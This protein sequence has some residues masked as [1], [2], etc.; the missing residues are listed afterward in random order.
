M[1]SSVVSVDYELQDAVVYGPIP[2]RRLGSSLGINPLPVSYKLCDF[3][4]VYCQYG[5]TPAKGTGE[6][7]KRAPELLAEIE[8]GL[9]HHQREGAPVDCITI[10]GNGEPTLHPDFPKLVEGLLK[11]RDRFFPSARVGVLSDSSQAYRSE[12]RGALEMLDDRYMKLDAGHAELHEKI[13]KPRGGFDFNRVIESLRGLRDIVSQSLF[14]QGSYDNTQTEALDK[15]I[16]TIGFIQPREVQVYSLDRKPADIGLLKVSP[17]RLK[18][19]A[20]VCQ[21]MTGIPT[22]V[23]D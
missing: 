19:I 11:L 5:W 23:Y 3:D 7:L 18:E 17:A 1:K 12:I 6:R 16:E 15:W 8:K 20:E 14:I 2:S 22:T 4:C 21:A 13:N 10:A 9:E